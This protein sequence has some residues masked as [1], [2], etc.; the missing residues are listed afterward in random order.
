M[1]KP[2]ITLILDWLAV[3]SFNFTGEHRIKYAGV[4]GSI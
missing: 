3:P 1:L 4:T 2:T